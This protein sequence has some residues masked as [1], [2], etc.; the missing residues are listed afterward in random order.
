MH[1]FSKLLLLTLALLSLVPAA[2]QK[3][4][5]ILGT[6]DADKT[7]VEI[8]KSGDD[9]IGHP[10]NRKGV[11]MEKIE[12]LNLS[13]ADGKWIGKLYNKRKDKLFDVVCEVEGNQLLLEVDAGVAT[14]T[15]EWSRVD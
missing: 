13:Y 2:A 7:K 1:T 10:L 14:R 5:A 6:W 9:F 8:F 11:R 3:S 15:V 4:D 12:L